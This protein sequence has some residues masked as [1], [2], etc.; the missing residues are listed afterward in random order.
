[1]SL[2][3]ALHPDRLLAHAVHRG[4]ASR[5]FVP[6]ALDAKDP[7]YLPSK[8]NWKNSQPCIWDLNLLT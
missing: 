7:T 1:M 3:R 2:G 4:G 8:L 5:S 6:L